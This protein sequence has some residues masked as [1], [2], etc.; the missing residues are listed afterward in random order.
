MRDNLPPPLYRSAN[1]KSIRKDKCLLSSSGLLAT[2]PPSLKTGLLAPGLLFPETIHS[3][4]Q[5]PWERPTHHRGLWSGSS[6]SPM[7]KILI[8]ATTQMNLEDIM[9][10]EIRQSHTC[11]VW[12]HLHEVPTV[13]KSTETEGDGR[14]VAK[15]CRRCGQ[16]DMGSCCSMG[17]EF[18]FY[19][20]KS[21]GNWLH[22]YMKVLNTIEL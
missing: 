19:K 10:P 1:R 22:S 14:L 3:T 12:F 13:V 5:H 2:P 7:I 18:S 20:M 4:G 16:D 21:F 11:T 8:Q 15:G 6:S 17:T 9:L